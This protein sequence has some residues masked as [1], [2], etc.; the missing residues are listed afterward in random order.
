MN[1]LLTNATDIFAG[2]EDY[3][4]ILARYLATARARGLGLGPAGSPAAAQVRRGIPPDRPSRLR[5]HG[6]RLCGVRHAS[7]RDA[8]AGNTDRAQQRQLRPHLR[9]NRVVVHVRPVTSR[10]CTAPIPSSTTS[11]TGC[12]TGTAPIISSP[13]PM[14]GR[15][16]WYGR[17]ASPLDR[18][19]TVP[20]GIESDDADVRARHRTAV[21]AALG[22]N[23]GTVV[24][25]NVARLVPFKGHRYLLE[26]MAGVVQTAGDAPPLIAGDGELESALEAQAASLGIAPH[27][28]FLGFRDD[29]HELYPAFDIYCHSSV[30]LA[31]EMFPDCHPPRARL[32]P[33]RRVHTRRRHRRHGGAGRHR[34][35]DCPGGSRRSCC[36]AS[37]A[38][39]KRHERGGRWGKRRSR[40]LNA[41]ITP[42][43]WPN[44]WNR[45]MNG[46][47][48]NMVERPMKTFAR[49]APDTLRPGAMSCLHFVRRAAADFPPISPADSLAIQEDNTMHRAEVDAFFR[50]DAASPVRARHRHPV[51]RAAS[52]SPSN[53]AFRGTLR[54]PPLCRPRYGRPSWER[55]AKNGGRSGTGILSSTSRGRRF[56]GHAPPECVQIHSL[57]QS[58]LRTVPGESERLVHRPDDRRRNVSG[59][60]VRRCR[61]R[62]PRPGARVHHRS[63]QGL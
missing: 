46:R 15:M 40:C 43:Q 34:P 20:I 54:A 52:G 38:Y 12:A 11:P 19:T 36:G 18:I 50:K 2:G 1:I 41:D 6:P 44:E 28:R 10:G 7:L 63:E 30:D 37:G 49:V 59:R 62:R 60:T 23:P 45:S 58:P 57:R 47:C 55:A 3:V 13:M 32:C 16:C 31:S 35:S 33:S 26:A 22:I 24:I 42:R 9:G 39:C 14:P 61:R 8:S 29:L 25:G 27:V 48:H 53:P 4:L 17:T 5:G 21:R 56:P 51:S